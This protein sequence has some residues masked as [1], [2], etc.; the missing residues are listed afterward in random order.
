MFLK[1]YNFSEKF[2]TNYQMI[3]L[4]QMYIKHMNLVDNRI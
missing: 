2:I 1:R 3:Y 4:E